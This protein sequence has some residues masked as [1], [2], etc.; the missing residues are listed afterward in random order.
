VMRILLLALMMIPCP[1]QAAPI[2]IVP[3]WAFEKHALKVGAGAAERLYGL[4]A[5]FP[6]SEAMRIKAEGG[7]WISKGQD[8]RRSS[9][10]VSVAWGYHAELESGLFGE[11]FI[12]PAWISAPDSQLGSNLQLQHTLGLGFQSKG[13]WALSARCYHFSNGSTFPGPNEGR[14]FCGPGFHIP[15]G[16]P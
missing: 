3:K 8:G 11:V 9:Y 5:L 6:I 10:Y 4:E 1:S 16:G 2:Q 13:G 12:G 7:G 14:D 15:I